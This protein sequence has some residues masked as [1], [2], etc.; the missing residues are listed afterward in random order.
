MTAKLCCFVGNEP[1]Y[2]VDMLAVYQ[3]ASLLCAGK[4]LCLTCNLPGQQGLYHRRGD[5]LVWTTNAAAKDNSAILQ[6][7]L[8]AE[9]GKNSTL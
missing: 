8:W 4:Q 7:L 6:S 9:K 1:Y 2:R 5:G 3:A